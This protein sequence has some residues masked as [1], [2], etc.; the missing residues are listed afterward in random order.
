MKRKGRDKEQ[1]KNRGGGNEG[2]DT[3]KGT[4]K[5]MPNLDTAVGL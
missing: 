5:K 4:K 3:V 2:G 1:K